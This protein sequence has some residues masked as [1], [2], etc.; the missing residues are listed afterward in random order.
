MLKSN[1]G[2]QEMKHE[3]GPWVLEKVQTGGIEKID[4]TGGD[5]AASILVVDDEAPI[6]CAVGSSL[7][8]Y[9]YNVQLASSGNEAIDLFSRASFDLILTDMLM[10]DGDGLNLLH[11]VHTKSPDM[12]VVI[13]TAVDDV[14]TAIGSM[15]RG[16]SDYIVKPIDLEQLATTIQRTLK[17]RRETLARRARHQDL[18]RELRTRSE[19]LRWAVTSLERS[20]DQMLVT[21]GDALDLRDSETEGHSKRVS[22]YTIALARA[23]K[24]PDSDV[25]Y[26]AQGALLHDIGKIAIPDAILLKPGKLSSEERG[27]MHEHCKCGFEMLSKIPFL[28]EAAE[29]VLMHHER[30]DGYG[31]PRGLR[32]SEIPLGARIFAIADALDAITSDR[33]YHKANTFELACR[34]IQKCSGTHFDPEVVEAFSKIPTAFWSRLR[35]ETGRESAD[36]ISPLKTRRDKHDVF[37]AG[38]PA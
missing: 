13:A 7:E 38:V 19:M 34:E 14:A 37:A 27:K 1:K 17:R 36:S 23:L 32:G 29:I 35:E 26:F 12:P 6:R 16:A 25:R 15:H 24:V 20:Q 28:A 22:A 2:H 33:P 8:S 4:S 30:F 9:G 11:R 3:T 21:L 10:Q 31:Y 18:E 5:P